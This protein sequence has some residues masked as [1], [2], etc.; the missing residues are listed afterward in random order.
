MTT[1]G[2]NIRRVRKERGL[3]Q[4]TLAKLSG[5][6]QPSISNIEGGRREPQQ[7]TLRKLADA[8]GVPPA[9]LMTE[10]DTTEAWE[11]LGR[12][13]D[14]TSVLERYMENPPDEDT[15]DRALAE[16]F[17]LGGKHLEI[18]I[19]HAEQIV[20]GEHPFDRGLMDEVR[21]AD[22]ARARVE[23]RIASF[24]DSLYGHLHRDAG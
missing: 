4:P 6:P 17:A 12:I 22:R 15:W 21:R 10:G 14:N 13:Q 23:G 16:F 8:L 18:A 5:V 20:A 11:T 1:I 9:T 19:R 7:A 2:Q 3:S 24:N